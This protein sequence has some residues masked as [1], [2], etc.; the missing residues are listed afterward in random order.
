MFKSGKRYLSLLSYLWLCTQ[1]FLITIIIRAMSSLILNAFFVFLFFQSDLK[2][3]CKPN[4][5]YTYMCKRKII[6]FI[7]WHIFNFFNLSEVFKLK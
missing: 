4:I 1:L 3:V 2:Y 5:I 6:I 7:I